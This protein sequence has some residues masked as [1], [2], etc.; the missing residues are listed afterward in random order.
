M[1]LG[2]NNWM[3]KKKK[4]IANV[5]LIIIEEQKFDVK[6]FTKKLNTYDLQ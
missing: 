3:L 5:I 1:V 6:C 2:H 4:I